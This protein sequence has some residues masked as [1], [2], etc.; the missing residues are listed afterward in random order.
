MVFDMQV[1]FCHANGVY[2]RL[3][4]L[5]GEGIQAII[6]N[7]RRAMLAAQQHK[8]PVIATK[9]TAFQDLDGEAI[10]LGHVAQLRPFLLKEGFRQGSAGQQVIPELPRP[11]YEVEKTRFSAFYSSSLEALL[12]ALQVQ[13]LVLTGIATNGAVEAT[14]RDAV[15]RDYEIITLE[16]C[17]TSFGAA[18]HQASLTNLAAMGKIS[19]SEE[20]VAGLSVKSNE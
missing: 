15:M 17:V 7:V 14:A 16:D 20:W 12:R 5:P 19:T 18:L 11:D 1:D 9:F 4:G 3:G 2:Q 6:P 13:E 8:V 10:G